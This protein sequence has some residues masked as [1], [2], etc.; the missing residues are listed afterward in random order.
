MLK[1][2]NALKDTPKIEKQVKITDQRGGFGI[3][4]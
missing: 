4:A 3:P 2:E 1:D